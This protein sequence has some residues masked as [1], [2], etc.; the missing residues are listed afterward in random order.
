LIDKI[1]IFLPIATSLQSITCVSATKILIQQLFLFMFLVVVDAMFFDL[2]IF[3]G[4]NERNRRRDLADA[5]EASKR[6]AEERKMAIA[7]PFTRRPCHPTL[8]TKVCQQIALLY[9][10]R[11]MNV[12]LKIVIELFLA[13]DTATR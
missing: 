10:A 8:V 3:S 6:E 1:V 11:H 5:E 7:D 13:E 4:I 2:S 9:L 12:T